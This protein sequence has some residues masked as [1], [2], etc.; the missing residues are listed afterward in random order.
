MRKPITKEY[1]RNYYKD[2]AEIIKARRKKAYKENPEYTFE[3][4]RKRVNKARKEAIEYYGNKCNCCDETIFRFL[5]IDHKNGRGN[6]HR[7]KLKSKS[8]YIWLRQNNYPKEF[9][10]LCFNCNCAKGFFG[11]CPHKHR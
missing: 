3:K 5:T 2:N 4:T 6:E 11:S 9:Q 1:Y 10:V 8:I 7:R